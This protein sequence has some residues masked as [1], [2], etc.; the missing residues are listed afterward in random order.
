MRSHAVSQVYLE[1]PSKELLTLEELS[2][3]WTFLANLPECEVAP[4]SAWYPPQ[5]LQRLSPLD[6]RILNRM[7]EL[8]LENKQSQPLQ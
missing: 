7:L 1:L 4:A 2:Q 5:N 8:E 6:W 3:A